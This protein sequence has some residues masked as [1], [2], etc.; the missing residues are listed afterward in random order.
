MLRSSSRVPS[1]PESGTGGG[2]TASLLVV[3]DEP[4]IAL[5][6]CVNLEAEGYRVVTACGGGEALD[7]LHEAVPD[8]VLLDVMMP[9][10]D[11]W[12][13]LAD[14]RRNPMTA[15]VPVVMLTAR[16]DDRD[17]LRAW[18]SGATDYVTKPFEP[19]ALVATVRDVLDPG[20]RAWIDRKRNE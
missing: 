8:L 4:D 11:G 3:D 12:A 13:V 14:I 6:C 15:N 2:V 1:A 18:Q 19:S 7:L 10:P 5:L 20:I 9:D 17:Q 16:A